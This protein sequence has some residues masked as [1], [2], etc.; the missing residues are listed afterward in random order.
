MISNAILKNVYQR[1]FRR[2]GRKG[3]T[4]NVHE[5][6]RNIGVLFILSTLNQDSKSSVK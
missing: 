3:T 6:F 4:N 2:A 5:I 1:N